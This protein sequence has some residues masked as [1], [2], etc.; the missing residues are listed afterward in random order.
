[1]SRRF[2][3]RGTRSSYRRPDG[4]F[5]RRPENIREDKKKFSRR[6]ESDRFLEES[7]RF[8][9]EEELKTFSF[10]DQEVISDVNKKEE[11]VLL[12]K[13]KRVSQGR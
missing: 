1:M 8:L 10:K 3:Y 2:S 5:P 7:D 13:S 4:F 12:K 9:V 6:E 11:K